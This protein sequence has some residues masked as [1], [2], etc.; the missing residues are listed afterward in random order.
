MTDETSAPV[1]LVPAATIV[2]LRDT[3]AG[4]EALL[5]KRNSKIAFGGMWAFPGGKVETADADPERPG[6]E[7]HTARRAAVRETVEETG[8]VLDP[9]A[10]VPFAHWVPPMTAPRRFSTWFFVVTAPFEAGV[11][12][13]QSEIHEH[14]WRRP[15]ECLAA[16]DAGE[17]E[18]APPTWV[19]LWRF[20]G[21]D[22]VDDA[23][24][25]ARASAPERFVTRI[26]LGDSPV[27]MWEADAGYAD[28][29]LTQAGVRHRL[30]MDRG[31]WRYETPA[32]PVG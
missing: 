15:V 28:G 1:A 3:S 29:D 7:L 31:G 5:L 17:I 10:L 4:P 20:R 23:V 11:V 25:H 9:A 30:L 27:A 13:D 14:A 32:G 19:S 6:E 16:R 18:L 8:L 21:F 2:L 26:V 22:R 24:A 12:V